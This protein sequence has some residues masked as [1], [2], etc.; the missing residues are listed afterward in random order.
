LQFK[1]LILDPRQGQ[2]RLL[3]QFRRIHKIMGIS[4]IFF[5]VILSFIGILLG[6]KKHSG[7]KILADTQTGINNHPE[8]WLS[9]D[10]LLKVAHTYATS[11]L[12]MDHPEVDRI[13]VRP[14]KG[15]LKI[16]FKNA[17]DGLQIDCTNG[18]VLLVEKR[19]SDM[20]EQI[21]DGSI[22][23]H[24]LG[25]KAGF[26]KLIYTT[27]MSLSLLTFCITGFWLYFGP[28]RLKRN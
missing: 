21:H 24:F 2:V 16:S 11:K 17:Y 23:D 3:R 13:E 25:L 12:N 19:Y 10:S 26:F 15:V 8:V 6:W 28:K 18:K 27:L 7:G 20:I 1:I 4:L 14:S 9:I 5:I 22:V